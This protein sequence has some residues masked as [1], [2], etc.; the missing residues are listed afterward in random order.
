MWTIKDH[1]NILYHKP[2]MSFLYGTLP[3]IFQPADG[4]TQTHK[5]TNVNVCN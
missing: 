4:T 3:L 2:E 1:N 5:N